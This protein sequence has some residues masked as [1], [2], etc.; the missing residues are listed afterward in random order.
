[1]PLVII[2]CIL[3]FKLVGARPTGVGRE[4]LRRYIHITSRNFKLIVFTSKT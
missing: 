3:I 1:M 2:E 4:V